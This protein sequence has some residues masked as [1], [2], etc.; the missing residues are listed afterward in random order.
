MYQ[1]LLSIASDFPQHKLQILAI[2]D[3]SKDDTWYWMQSWQELG[4]QITLFQQ[5][6]NKGKRHALYRGLT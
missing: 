6:S 2:D 5:P 3:G 1:T 4:D